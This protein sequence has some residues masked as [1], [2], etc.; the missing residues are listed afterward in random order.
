MA[1][2]D[3]FELGWSLATGAFCYTSLGNRLTICQTP[4]QS[5]DDLRE[6]LEE[7]G[8]R[9]VPSRLSPK[10]DPFPLLW[11]D[12][13]LKTRIKQTIISYIHLPS[14][15]MFSIR[16]S[17]SPTGPHFPYTVVT[18]TI[19]AFFETEHEARQAVEEYMRIMK[20]RLLLS[21]EQ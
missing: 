8:K 20:L 13:T 2:P 12:W 21:Q 19:K 4:S 18:G 6:F 5:L 1:K 3:T 15:A 16:L 9:I 10:G 11:G 17:A 14:K 7:N